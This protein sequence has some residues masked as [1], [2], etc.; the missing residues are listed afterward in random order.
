MSGRKMDQWG[1]VETDDWMGRKK[2]GCIGEKANWRVGGQRAEGDG[3]FA[4]VQNGWLNRKANETTILKIIG[5]YHRKPQK[6]SVQTGPWEGDQGPH[7][8]PEGTSPVQKPQQLSR[9]PLA[10]TPGLGSSTHL[11]VVRPQALEAGGPQA[12]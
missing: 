10:P 1:L 6:N 4:V 7:R 8:R 2:H 3:W 5:V 12:Q 11:S 9:H